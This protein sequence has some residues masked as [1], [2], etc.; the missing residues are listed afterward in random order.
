MNSQKPQK[1]RELTHCSR[2]RLRRVEFTMGRRRCGEVSRRESGEALIAL[3]AGRHGS[4][5]LR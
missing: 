3:I 4:K 2:T 5:A 1:M